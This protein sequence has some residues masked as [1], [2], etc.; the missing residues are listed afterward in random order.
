VVQIAPEFLEAVRGRQ[1]IGV[2]AEMVLAEL[3]GVV[4]KVEQEL[5]DGRRAGPQIG[6]AAGQLRRDHARAQRVHAGEEGVAPRS[7]ALLGV[8]VH[9]PGAFLA[10]AVYVGRFADHQSLMVDARLHPADVVAHDEEDIGL[11]WLLRGC[12]QARRDHGDEQ[13]QHAEPAGSGRHFAFHQ[14][15]PELDAVRP[16][17]SRARAWPTQKLCARRATIGH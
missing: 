14:F 8:I 2:V 1:G 7:A 4:A 16:P 13:C 10:D 9:E 17:R 12:R 3:T 5:G 11:L 15:A 6:R